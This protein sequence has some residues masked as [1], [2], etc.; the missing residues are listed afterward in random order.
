[1][2]A[3]PCGPC[4][5]TAPC[6]P[7][8]PGTPCAPCGPCGPVGPCGITKSSTTFVGVPLLLTCASEP[9]APVIVL[10]TLTVVTGQSQIGGHGL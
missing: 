4:G 10:P 2:P 9:G 8:R 5:P 6:G 1:M 3:I 7:V